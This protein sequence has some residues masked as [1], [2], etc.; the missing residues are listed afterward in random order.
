MPSLD[1]TTT[2]SQVQDLLDASIDDE[3]VLLDM[4]AEKIY[5]MDPVASRVWELLA[6]PRNLEEVC[7]L[8][9]QEFD[10]DRSI[11]ERDVLDYVGHL[12]EA[13]LVNIHDR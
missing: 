12:I 1:L 8:L 11:C 7:D 10:V 6:Q 13:N 9:V 3:V 2:L 4:Q 5:G